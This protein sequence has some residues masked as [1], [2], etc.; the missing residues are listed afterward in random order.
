MNHPFRLVRDSINDTRKPTSSKPVSGL[1]GG[2]Q[3]KPLQPDWE[4]IILDLQL[5]G[6]LKIIT[7]NS[8]ATFWHK[9]ALGHVINAGQCYLIK[10]E[11]FQLACNHSNLLQASLV[12]DNLHDCYKSLRLLDFTGEE[13]L[14]FDL[15]D[16]SYIKRYYCS[17]IKH[18][19]KPSTPRLVPSSNTLSCL[20]RI[21]QFIVNE[22]HDLVNF[23][24]VQI[25]ASLVNETIEA[26]NVIPL[27][28]T[29][30]DQH[31]NF[32]IRTGNDSALTSYEDQFY[33]FE[34]SVDFVK[35]W[36]Q[37]ASF[38]LDFSKIVKAQVLIS[39]EIPAKKEVVLYDADDH[40]IASIGMSNHASSHHKAIW[41]QVLKELLN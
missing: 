35:L 2:I 26:S 5:Y 1:S 21:Q 3:T 27:L 41:K 20:Q 7:C 9:S 13:L 16:K 24:P 6:Q 14:R 19:S 33:Y 22:T 39:Q 17:L 37:K 38:K 36:N 25:D 30:I 12:K 10:G 23:I 29:L 32:T 18:W 40:C 15:T 31:C 28:E 34:H 11:N 8:A 4:R